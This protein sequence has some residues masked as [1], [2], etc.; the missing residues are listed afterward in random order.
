MTKAKNDT[1]RVVV[2]KEGDIWIAQALEHDICAQGAD[3]DAVTERLQEA[4]AAEIG[5]AI[6]NGEDPLAD[7]QPAP[8]NFF[9]MWDERS[10]FTTKGERLQLA[11][12][13]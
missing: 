8:S 7:I 2:F 4:V 1:L 12:C 3:L 9:R 13:A 6:A 10:R 11:L 5:L